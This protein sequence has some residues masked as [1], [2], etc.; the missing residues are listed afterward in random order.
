MYNDFLFDF[1][2]N[3]IKEIK[4][5]FYVIYC[6]L[7]FEVVVFQNFPASENVFGKHLQ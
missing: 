5:L 4:Y 3:T 1:M 6:F 7:V 2:Y